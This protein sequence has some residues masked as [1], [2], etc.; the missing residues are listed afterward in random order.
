MSHDAEYEQMQMIEEKRGSWEAGRINEKVARLAT[1]MD[2]IQQAID[3]IRTDIQ[4]IKER[5]RV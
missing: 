4:E 5:L 1:R 2:D 3:G